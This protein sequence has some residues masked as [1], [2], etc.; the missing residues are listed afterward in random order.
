[1]L[2]DELAGLPPGQHPF[3]VWLRGAKPV[4]LFRRIVGLE[5][6]LNDTTVGL[7]LGLTEQIRMAPVDASATITRRLFFVPDHPERSMVRMCEGNSEC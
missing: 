3:G 4:V 6:G 5:I 2:P 1:M 7:S